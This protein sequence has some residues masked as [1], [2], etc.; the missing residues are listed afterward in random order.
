VL[1]QLVANF[2]VSREMAPWF[3]GSMG[4]RAA[5]RALASPGRDDGAFLVRFSESQ[6]TKFTLS[7]L[8][9]HAESGRREVKNCLVENR[10][11]AGGY[12]LLEG[13]QSRHQRTYTSLQTFVKH[14]ASRLK[15]G[16]RGGL[17][18]QHQ[19]TGSNDRV[20]CIPGPI[21]AGTRVQ[22]RAGGPA[23]RV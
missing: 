4:R 7:Y 14:N 3:H 1:I 8:K 19:L 22:L 2:C 18:I 10:G 6:P 17:C 9:V 13:S 15:L 16:V 5:E 11:R 21:G 23:R 12:T 20:T